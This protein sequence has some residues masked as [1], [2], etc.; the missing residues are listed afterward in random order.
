LLLWASQIQQT[1]DGMLQTFWVYLFATLFINIFS[2]Q[3]L[4]K[5][6]VLINFNLVEFPP[7]SLHISIASLNITV[8]HSGNVTKQTGLTVLIQFGPGVF[9]EVHVLH[10]VVT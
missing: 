3:I 7:G 10:T 9:T 8:M 6:I 2:V 1:A 5:F 4:E